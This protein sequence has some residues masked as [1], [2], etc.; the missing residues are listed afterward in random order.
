MWTQNNA[1]H[2]PRDRYNNHEELL[3][4]VTLFCPDT[5][6]E[7]RALY[8]N[9]KREQLL[10]S[11]C[12]TMF[13]DSHKDILRKVTI[14]FVMSATVNEILAV[15]R[16]RHCE[17]IDSVQQ[18]LSSHFNKFGKVFF[19]WAENLESHIRAHEFANGEVFSPQR[20]FQ[21]PEK[22]E[23]HCPAQAHEDSCS[24]LQEV[25]CPA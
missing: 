3:S 8:A 5:C 6:G 16:K 10:K 9:S 13:Y 7:K 14:D 2:M 4:E 17:V 24:Q 12:S 15:L 20:F 22:S 1:P 25:C 23:V 11:L 19:R 21:I 18:S